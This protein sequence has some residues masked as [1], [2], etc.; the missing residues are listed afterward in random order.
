MDQIIV[1][2]LIKSEHMRMEEQLNRRSL[3][4]DTHRREGI[5]LL[6]AIRTMV[7][8]KDSQAI[9]PVHCACCAPS[10]A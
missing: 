6:T 4:D 8:R 7:G 2:T 10:Q 9:T 3:V 1:T 5:R